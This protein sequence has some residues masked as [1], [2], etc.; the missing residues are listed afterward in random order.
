MTHRPPARAIVEMRLALGWTQAHL[1][2]ALGVDSGTISRW[3]RGEREAPPYLL[4]AI[5]H[6]S[7]QN[8]GT[9]ARVPTERSKSK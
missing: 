8:V 1:A 3:E 9:S 6:L 7:C 2:A 4:A 5:E